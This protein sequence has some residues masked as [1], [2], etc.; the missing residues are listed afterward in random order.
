MPLGRR[1][2]LTALAAATAFS[3]AITAG[4]NDARADGP[5]TPTGKGIAGGALL[6]GEVVCIPMGAAGVSRAWPYLVFCP[7]GAVAGGVGGYFVEQTGVA[8]PSLYMLAGGLALIIPTLVVTINATAYKPPE[9]D[10]TDQTLIQEPAATPPAPAGQPGA[11]P[12]TSKRDAK[13]RQHVAKGPVVPHIPM[14]FVDVYHG[15]ISLGLPA[16]EIKPL[17]SQKELTQYGV[18]QGNEVKVPIFKAMF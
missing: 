17:Y 12:P 11:P 6:G 4:T 8:E 18:T 3:L 1:N 14:S 7:L 16:L 2:Q 10:R 5:V 9:V 13:P 15:R